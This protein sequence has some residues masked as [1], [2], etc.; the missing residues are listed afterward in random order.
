M[1]T[2]GNKDHFK[3]LQLHEGPQKVTGISGELEIAS[4][5]TFVFRI[6]SDDGLVDTVKIP[7]S[8]YVPDLKF[9]LMSPQH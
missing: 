5:G 1:D 4:A 6:Q 9:P 3:D 2:S 8:H 7:H